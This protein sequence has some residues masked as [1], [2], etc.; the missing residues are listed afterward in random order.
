[1]LILLV[2]IV[3]YCTSTLIVMYQNIYRTMGH[4]RS[5]K[6]S[7][8]IFCTNIL[9]LMTY[10]LVCMKLFMHEHLATHV[11]ASTE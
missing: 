3:N 6:F 10:S 5:Q 7:K 8:K 2:S 9:K 4:F 1:M 11:L